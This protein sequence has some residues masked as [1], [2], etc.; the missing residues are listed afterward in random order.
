MQ[1]TCVLA[2]SASPFQAFTKRSMDDFSFPYTLQLATRTALPYFPPTK[3][4]F[5]IEQKD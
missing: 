2:V 3:V 5:V 4:G 1:Q